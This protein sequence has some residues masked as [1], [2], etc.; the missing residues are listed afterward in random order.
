MK[1]VLERG[2]T[3]RLE[4]FT[5]DLRA[6]LD[7]YGRVLGFDNEAER[8]GGYTPL[9]KGPVRIALNLRSDL[10]EDHPIRMN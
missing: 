6:S 5:S 3:L 8:P 10:D 2:A 7:F 1:R 4:L 9:A